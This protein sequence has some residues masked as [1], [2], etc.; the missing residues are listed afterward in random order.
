MI[1]NRRYHGAR[2][3]TGCALSEYTYVR[4]SQHL[5]IGNDDVT[6]C[7]KCGQRLSIAEQLRTEDVRRRSVTEIDQAETGMEFI[8]LLHVRKNARGGGSRTKHATQNCARRCS[9]YSNGL[10]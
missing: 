2:A 7:E 10:S 4:L 1:Q 8:P 5:R 9:K 3:S 6:P